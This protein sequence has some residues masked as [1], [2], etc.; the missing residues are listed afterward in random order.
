MTA[1]YDAIVI[2]GGSAGLA[3]AQEA[4]RLNARVLLVERA[5]LGGTCVNRGCVPKKMMWTVADMMHR[6]RTFASNGI[7]GDALTL[8]F[9][10]L[11]D[12]RASQIDNIVDSFADTLNDAGVTRVTG[13][14]VLQRDGSITVDAQT[15]HSDKIIVATGTRPSGLPIPGNDLMAVSDDVF[16]WRAVPTSLIVIGGGYIGCEMASIFQAFG[17]RVTIVSDSDAVLTEFSPAS[18]KIAAQ[19]LRALGV[20][21][22]LSSRPEKVTKDGETLRVTLESG[23]T[24]DATHVLNATGR[25]A[26]LG[27]FGNV[28]VPERTDHGPL[29]INDRFETSRKGVYAVGDVADRLPLTPVARE[30]GKILARQLFG[31]ASAKPVD[32]ADVATTAFVMPPIGEV[33]A[34]GDVAELTTFTAM[35]SL[36]AN[37][38]LSEAWALTRDDTGGLSGAVVVGHAAA[39]AISWAAQL[40]KRQPTR[41]DMDRAVSIHPSKAEE[42]LGSD[43]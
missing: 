29:K 2:G 4:A 33:G 14:A 40:V 3:F 37:D 17:S 25:D 8:H 5:Q 23:D 41:A 12:K 42:P 16:G 32:L 38:D 36:I 34:T 28:D 43:S 19:N 9:D 20:N 31:D 27:V 24:L 15:Y 11:A 39:E 13:D 21:I 35:E 6:H 30:D 10:A 7:L 26:N 1:P 22:V 18:Q